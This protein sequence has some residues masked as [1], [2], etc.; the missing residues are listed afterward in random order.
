[1]IELGKGSMIEL[2]KGSMIELGKGSMINLRKRLYEISGKGSIGKRLHN[3]PLV[4]ALQ[5]NN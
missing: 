5:S 2:G 3:K 1:M 4:K